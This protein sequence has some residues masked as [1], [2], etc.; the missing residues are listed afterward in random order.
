[1]TQVLNKT[2]GPLCVTYYTNVNATVADSLRCHMIC[3]TVLSSV[4]AW[5]PP[6]TAATWSPAAAHSKPLPRQASI[7]QIS[8]NHSKFSTWKLAVVW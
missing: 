3:G 6:A 1:V 5:M 2:S 4:H 7:L 8:I